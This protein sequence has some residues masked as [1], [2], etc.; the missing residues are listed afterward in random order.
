MMS[1]GSDGVESTKSND[2]TYVPDLGGQARCLLSAALNAAY[3]S[4]R[5]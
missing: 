5:F 3:A 4:Y 2:D 1:I